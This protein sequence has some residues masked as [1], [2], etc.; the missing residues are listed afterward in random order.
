MRKR[1]FLVVAVLFL[2]YQ[3]L[4][5]QTDQQRASSK[6]PVSAFPTADSLLTAFDKTANPLQKWELL[7]ELSE[8]YVGNQ[9]DSALLYAQKTLQLAKD[10][11]PDKV[12]MSYV[13]LGNFYVENKLYEKAGEILPMAIERAEKEQCLPCLIE[14]FNE[15][16]QIPLD[17]LEFRTSLDFLREGLAASLQLNDSFYLAKTLTNMS[18]VF[19]QIPENDSAKVYAEQAIAVAEPLRHQHLQYNRILRV[20]HNNLGIIHQNVGKDQEA[21]EEFEKCAFYAKLDN[22]KELEAIALFNVADSYRRLGKYDAGLSVL[23]ESGDLMKALK[24]SDLLAYYHEEK[25]ALLSHKGQHADALQHFRMSAN[26]ND[27]LQTELY[28]K[29]LTDAETRFETKRI[30]AENAQ[31]QLEIEYQNKIKTWI[32]GSALLLILI[33]GAIFQFFR[34]RDHLKKKEA[35]MAFHL[36][37]A[38]ATKLRELDR[39]KS[40]FFANIS[41]EFRTPLTLIQGPLSTAKREAETNLADWVSISSKYVRIMHRNCSR[42][43]QLVNQLLDLSKVEAGKLVLQAAEGDIT[44]FVQV[45]GGSFESLAHQREIAFTVSVPD[46]TIMLWFD[47]D[48]LEKVLVNLL[49]NAFKFTQE[50]GWV[51]LRLL[52]PTDEKKGIVRIDVQD[53]GIGIP[54]KQLTSIFDRFYQ[55]DD[56]AT[57]LQAGTGIGL[58]LAKELVSLHH[59]QIK[60]E[61]EEGQ[62]THF[63]L[64][65]PLGNAH[66]EA[67]EM[68]D[69]P[70]KRAVATS[71]MQATKEGL[72]ERQVGP[73]PMATDSEK[74]LVLLIED[75]PDV[76]T[77]IADQLGEKYQLLEAVNGREGLALAIEKIPDLIVSDIMMPEMDGKALCNQLKKDERT[78][79]IPIILLTALAGQEAKLEG[80]K[81]GAD[82]YLTKPFSGEELQLRIRNLIAQRQHL[83]ALYGKKAFEL[84]PSEIAV[85]SVEENFLT[86]LIKIIEENMEDEAF[87]VEDLSSAV[88]LS[89]Y[90]LLRKIKALTGQSI[91]VFIR[92]IRLERAYQLLSQKAGNATEV[93]YLVGFS[94]P[95]Y[96]SKCFKDKFGKAPSEILKA[97]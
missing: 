49:S 13:V 62:G 84:K 3:F 85:S 26:L 94:G 11:L 72:L 24:R 69:S 20:S 10:M 95:A 52:R 68:T 53:N 97:E 81:T 37:Q 73:K 14:A 80:L 28:G 79:H 12:T 34:N 31:Q 66:L 56:S 65:L 29:N 50:E 90:Q 40:S 42:L 22:D 74:A 33:L 18:L 54:N 48:K 83:Q 92:N 4:L 58:S 8:F 15:L 41:H 87:S 32:I 44:R 1:Y 88:A 35:E 6:H 91:S 55:V 47:Q 93:C 43:L 57:R 77:Y 96:F 46:Q 7:K 67:F 63:R 76:R 36:E 70:V 2:G 19:S 23:E 17:K 30:E 9:P 78:S 45:I 39:L 86:N 21:A 51:A 71:V 27:S 64:E 59:G 82:D 5:S 60:V 89:R 61:S 16:F 25:A 38:E 75:H